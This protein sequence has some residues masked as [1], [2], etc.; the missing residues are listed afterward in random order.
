MAHF[1]YRQSTNDRSLV[2]RTLGLILLIA[3]T[4]ALM[5]LLI[6]CGGPAS[7]IVVRSL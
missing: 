2:V 1:N 6:A 7:D 3:F 4:M 5:L